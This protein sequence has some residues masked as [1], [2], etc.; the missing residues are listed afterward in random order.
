MR[1][2][3]TSNKKYEIVII[4]VKYILQRVQ[5]QDYTDCPELKEMDKNKPNT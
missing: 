1:K 4:A 5:Q 3:P 2:F